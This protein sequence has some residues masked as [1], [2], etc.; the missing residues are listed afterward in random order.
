MKS[1]GEQHMEASDVDKL[2]LSL[3]EGIVAHVESVTVTSAKNADSGSK[4]G[5]RLSESTVEVLLVLAYSQLVIG[6]RHSYE[7]SYNLFLRA[8]KLLA[9]DCAGDK[10]IVKNPTSSVRSLASALYNVA[11]TLYNE[12]KPESAI[13][14]IKL[15]CELTDAG[16]RQDGLDVLSQA[17]D[18]LSIK[19]SKQD[20]SVDAAAAKSEVQHDLANHLS[21]RFE[22]LALC[23]Q[24][25][26][27]KQVCVQCSL[28]KREFIEL[29]SLSSRTMHSSLHF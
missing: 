20:D 6:D 14:F 3:L 27:E 4:T 23:Q 19:D 2:L 28:M 26:G 8:A 29:L 18:H 22:L 24:A 15:S 17:L 11:G 7:T 5:R 10:V 13:K 9:P 25:I 21:K 12:S 1:A 16:V